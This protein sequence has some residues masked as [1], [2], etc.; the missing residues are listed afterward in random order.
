MK[1]MYLAVRVLAPAVN[2]LTALINVFVKRDRKI[3]L[4]GSWMGERYSDNS[5][6][7]FQ[8]LN[9]HIGEYE[10]RKA[11]W[12]TRNKAVYRLLR[13]MNCEVYMMHSL[14]SF[15]YHF[16]AGI[17]VICNISFPVKGFSG[18][19]MGHL[20]GN[21]V[22]I[23]MLHGIAI[24]A[25][26]STGANNRTGSLSERIRYFLR[27]DRL[28]CYAFTPG[29]WDHA[30]LLSS[31]KECTRRNALFCGVDREWFIESGFPRN[32][33]N[34]P[35]TGKERK[36]IEKIRSSEHSVLY[37]PTFREKGETPHP[38]SSRAVRDLLKKN[39]CLWIEKPHPMEKGS[40]ANEGDG[41]DVLVLAPDFDINVV[42]PHISLLITDY[43]SVS[44]DAMAVDKP[45]LFYA[46]DYDHYLKQE[47][48]FLCDYQELIRGFSAS[49]PEELA[50]LLE[51][52]FHDREFR[53]RL[54]EKTR[55]E[56][57]VMFEKQGP[58][59][60]AIAEAV[61]RRLGI[62]KRKQRV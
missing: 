36:V 10:I 13:S 24:K 4:F 19:I 60:A 5:R 50:E 18:D 54:R 37:V 27:N 59:E 20:S 51:K 22:K 12:V 43:S 28:F 15:Y 17:H 25:G 49:S 45:V 62:F 38:F 55:A 1:Y 61:S 3:V 48:G 16:K 56:K 9:D 6:F 44:Y 30:Y 35:V 47:R 11:V 2:A 39:G 53:E 42:L 46:A 7:F 58:G 8:Y 41:K 52:A 26:K 29:H 57:K 31:G 33:G 34:L 32:C 23:N 40:F 21:A 14:K